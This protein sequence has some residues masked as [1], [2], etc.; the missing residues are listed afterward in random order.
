MYIY[1]YERTVFNE[2]IL[3]KDT[4]QNFKEDFPTIAKAAKSRHVNC[5]YAYRLE[6][7][8]YKLKDKF[9]ERKMKV[10]NQELTK[11]NHTKK[12]ILKQEVKL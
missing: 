11:L 9:T 2:S 12:V 4:I 5:I 10:L 1:Y 8:K 3:R 7:L 6:Q